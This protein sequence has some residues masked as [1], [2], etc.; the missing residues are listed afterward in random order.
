ME[1][2]YLHEVV[3]FLKNID[4]ERREQFEEYFSTAPKWL[5]DSFQIVEMEK[6]VTLVRENAPV[7]RVYIIGKGAVKGVDFRIYGVEYDFMHFDGVY[8]MGAMEIVL[9]EDVYRTTLETLTP[10][11]VIRIPKEQFEK[12]LMSDIKALRQ[13]SR[14]I[15]KYLLEEVRNTRLNLFLKGTDRL[16]ILFTRFYEKYGGKG[17]LKITYTRTE[18]SEISGLCVKTI[19]RSVQRF[20]E[21]GLVGRKG[22]K[23]TVNWEQ[24]QRLRGIVDELA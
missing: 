10:C 23:V 5:L 16:A 22:S 13:E 6:G 19:N 4:K 20:E 9:G 24:Y 18:L 21:E 2:Q 8:G 3:P 7:D 1:K 15:G 12:W 17:E 11:T 14:A